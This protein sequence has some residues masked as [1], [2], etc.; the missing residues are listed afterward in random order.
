[1]KSVELPIKWNFSPETKSII[2][3]D[4]KI[5]AI[6]ARTT[7]ERIHPSMYEITEEKV[8]NRGQIPQPKR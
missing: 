1:M 6:N 3:P 4:G 8:S 7:K 2:T 5:F